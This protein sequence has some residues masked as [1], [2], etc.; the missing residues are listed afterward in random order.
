MPLPA[1]KKRK[2]A[3]TPADDDE[4]DWSG[5]SSDQ[6]QD[7]HENQS[8]TED[9]S[10][11][12]EDSEILLG[13]IA[14]ENGREDE[15]EEDDEEDLL[16]ED[17]GSA[18]D[19][20]INDELEDGFTTEDALGDDM[21]PV[22]QV[23]KK[24]DKPRN[25]EVN[26]TQ[27][28]TL[29]GDSRNGNTRKDAASKGP[30]KRASI[31]MYSA[32]RTRSNGLKLQI[33]ELLDEIRPSHGER[34]IAAEQ[35][36]RFL[37][38][39][40]E[41]IPE[42]DPLPILEAEEQMMKSHHIR[43]PFPDP[44]PTEGTQYKLQ[45]AK[46][47]NLNVIGSYALKTRSA[48]DEVVIDLMVEMPSSLF[49][50]KDYLDYRYFYRRA[51]Y[52]SCLAAGMLEA[53]NGDLML[54][55]QYFHGNSLLPIVVVKPKNQ[56]EGSDHSQPEYSIQVIPSAPNNLFPMSKTTPN[57]KCIRN[58]KEPTPFYNAS[59]RLDI[60]ILPYL[61]FVHSMSAKS[62]SFKDACLLGRIWLRQRG[63][64]S[65]LSGGFGNFEW[66]T[67][68]ALLL[69][70]DLP[71]GVT[72]LSP[73]FDGFQMFKATLQFLASR[74]LHKQPLWYQSEGF[75]TPS[76]NDG[77]VLFDGIR[78]INILY[79]M[80]ASSYRVFRHE[81]RTSIKMFSDT[82]HDPFEA[83]FIIRSDVPL[84]R[85]DAVVR[86]PPGNYIYE[87]VYSI[88]SRGLGDR[89]SLI[90]VDTSSRVG[91]VPQWSLE[92]ATPASH[93]NIYVQVGLM[94]NGSN[95][96]RLVDHGPLAEEPDESA[97]FRQF[98]GDKAE[99]RRFK[100]GS[101][102]ESLVW[103][104]KGY[105]S[106]PEQIIEH[107]V[108]RHLGAEVAR[109][110]SFRGSQYGRMVSG[111]EMQGTS[112]FQAAM[113]AFETLEKDI[114]ALD[115]L[116]LE[117]RQIMATD[118]QLR[119]SSIDPP[120]H[121]LSKQMTTPTD[122]VIQFEGSGRWPDDLEAIQ[123]VKI[124]F[125]LKLSS[126]I[127][128]SNSSIK[129]RLG[130]ENAQ[131]AHF[132]RSFLDVIYPTGMSFRIRI[133]HDREQHL[134]ETQLKSPHLIQKDKEALG[135]ALAH[136]KRTFLRL[137]AHTQA[138]QIAC[139]RFPALSPTIRLAKKWFATHL[140][141]PHLSEPLIELLVA[142]TFLHPWP[143]EAP[144]SAMPGLLRTLF[145]LSRWDWRHEPL[146]VD[147]SSRSSSSAATT[148]SSGSENP[149]MAAPSIDP[150]TL[151]TRFDAWRRI[152][153]A[154]HRVVL[155]VASSSGAPDG[156]EWTEFRPAKVVAARMTS[157]ARAATERVLADGVDLV[158]ER[159][160]A[161]ALREYDF[162]IRMR[163]AVTQA[164]RRR[165]REKGGE[166][167]FKNLEVQRGVD[168]DAVRFDPVGAF[169]GELEE[170]YG[171]AVVFF[172]DGY[173]GDVIAG[174][175]S[176]HTARRK[177]KVHLDYSSMPVVGASEDAGEVDINKEAILGEIAR[178]GGDMIEK[179]EINK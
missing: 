66:V 30:E 117:I 169:L 2:L 52:L 8:R 122:V 10:E 145:F 64:G 55:F 58:D 115:G 24:P 171:D 93:S 96:N 18:E 90:H 130:L 34:E 110:M 28:L 165:K 161:H 1:R 101:I 131:Q 141:S 179:I 5:Y 15:E 166:G 95:V 148:S 29:R 59:L 26:G 162:V 76:Y 39:S 54:S 36:L 44:R 6:D 70:T 14:N 140:L 47:T 11:V 160:F 138:I 82:K 170:V 27:N 113:L 51:Y 89:M 177:W 155:F 83:S 81:A 75:A 121:G 119:F 124:A 62:D 50:E 105:A 63:F 77:P 7:V 85:Y 157:L 71:R 12:E 147:F 43:V 106:I 146:L 61:K 91:I 31:S 3:V 20:G 68:M 154:L 74:N 87:R 118:C 133:H 35:T 69:Q 125:L 175:W 41:S 108:T 60:M 137:P 172:Y 168:V 23:E 46:P 144:A 173:R 40:I 178:L 32:G 56:N 103:T 17:D 33:E 88:L 150:A 159:L 53:S 163:E 16:A 114:R 149:T 80:T 13:T 136:Y 72:K 132:N 164:G 142:R 116:P 158:P 123:R 42:T 126:L 143:W 57:K 67:V 19:F 152:D 128:T 112:S 21:E 129:T 92:S 104:G 79:K 97:K 45:Y 98:W 135:R 84:L 37:K 156:T 109:G 73:G 111:G 102:R 127:S 4:N 134:L 86:F 174:L 120:L 22:V 94:F 48:L 9:E 100:D 25:R 49:Q 107:V 65:S 99:L 153:P 167:R 38:A 176:P 151:A 139:T 78:G